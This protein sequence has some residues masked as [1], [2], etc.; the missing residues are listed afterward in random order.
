MVKSLT[1]GDVSKHFNRE[2]ISK[3][4]KV[5]VSSKVN[6]SKFKHLVGDKVVLSK[7]CGVPSAKRAKLSKSSSNARARGEVSKSGWF[8][9]VNVGDKMQVP[10]RRSKYPVMS[11]IITDF[12]LEGWHSGTPVTRQGCYHKVL[13]VAEK[14]GKF[15]NQYLDPSKG[16]AQAQLCHWLSRVLKR[17]G[18][19]SRKETVSQKVPENWL[20]LSKAFSE[21]A[22]KRF[23]DVSVDVVV[24][25]DQTFIKFRLADENLLVPTGLRR[26]GT[27]T[28]ENDKRKGVSLMLCSFVS[29]DLGRD[30]FS[31]G[32]LPPF[33]VF[34]GKTGATLDKR[35]SDWRQRPGHSGS[36]NFQP[37]HWFDK[38]IT[39]RWIN[40][41][42]AQ[43]PIG[44][45]IGLVWDACPSH[46]ASTVANR[47][48]ELESEGRLFTAIIP[49][50]MTSILQLGV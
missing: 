34:N 11:K 18:F 32:I 46:N 12:V 36:M 50:G 4:S 19:S 41:L 27:T 10:G 22:L 14:G 45:R 7:F 28:V 37:R 35:Y 25:A 3:Y 47:L 33:L 5:E 6:L 17:M 42:V 13:E 24:C 29:K 20:N 40:W 38:V 44:L 23:R 49:G 15:F 48:S 26:V 43:F 39:L 9:N 16:G 21:S 1:W 30:N 31:T 2:I 8:I